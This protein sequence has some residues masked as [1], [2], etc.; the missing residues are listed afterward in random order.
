MPN[1]GKQEKDINQDDFTI[2]IDPKTQAQMVDDAVKAAKV[3][4]EKL[5][6]NIKVWKDTREKW[7]KER[8]TSLENARKAL[9]ADLEGKITTKEF[10]KQTS[11]VYGFF[12]A[13]WAKMTA[14]KKTAKI[15]HKIQELDRQIE[16]QKQALIKEEE[17]KKNLQDS[18]I[19]KEKQNIEEKTIDSKG[20]LGYHEYTGKGYKFEQARS[21]TLAKTDDEL[22]LTGLKK[23]VYDRAKADLQERKNE[24]AAKKQANDNVLNSLVRD[25]YDLAEI[26]NVY[27]NRQQLSKICGKLER[28]DAEEK[29]DDARLKEIESEKAAIKERMQTIG[30]QMQLQND[31]YLT[32]KRYYDKA[33]ALHDKVEM[34]YKNAMERFEKGDTSVK[35][36]LDIL[37]KQYN[38]I[39]KKLRE[40]SKKH[41]RYAKPKEHADMNIAGLQTSLSDLEEEEYQL[42]AMKASRANNKL[43]LEAERD[44]LARIDSKYQKE[45][46]T[47]YYQAI[48][49]S[50]Q[51]KD[52]ENQIKNVE[53]AQTNLERDVLNSDVTTFLIDNEANDNVKGMSINGKVYLDEQ[54]LADKGITDAESYS[55]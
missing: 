25:E 23:S 19:A 50:T 16:A 30:I 33:L 44:N 1:P 39:Q 17:R 34:Q 45:L 46:G 43:S 47:G 26:K 49:S 6:K 52:L 36:Q 10:I 3:A 22:Q 13:I 15:T 14:I 5:A 51:N 28:F 12:G 38:K 4:Q 7:D 18:V 40:I 35:P 32:S 8:L 27:E 41:A 37:D 53:L 48:A 2:E 11:Q 21:E 31:D 54:E 9:A 24:L 20:D 29:A 42:S 55:V